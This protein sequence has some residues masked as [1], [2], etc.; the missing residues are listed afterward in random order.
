[1][2]TLECRVWAFSFLVADYIRLYQ[3]A[4]P[5]YKRA[6]PVSIS[7][8]FV[9]DLKIMKMHTLR[10]SIARVHFIHFS[11]FYIVLHVPSHVNKLNISLHTICS[12]G[13]I[14]IFFL[15]IYRLGKCSDQGRVAAFWI[16]PR[17]PNAD[18]F[19]Q[20]WHIDWCLELTLKPKYDGDR[21]T[22]HSYHLTDL[23]KS[24]VKQKP[25]TETNK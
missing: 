25:K 23:G 12:L 21:P 20:D 6:T 13:Q 17:T 14:W 10:F 24:I 11:F 5:V 22:R 16:K 3:S 2:I 18:S 1:M 4:S 19:A 15:Q 8:L 9:S 7:D